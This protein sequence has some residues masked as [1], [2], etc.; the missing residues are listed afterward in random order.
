MEVVTNRIVH[1]SLLRLRFRPCLPLEHDIV[2]PPGC[3]R[4]RRIGVLV[5]EVTS[6]LTV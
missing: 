5:L 6:V 3:Q 1:E 4:R 2:I